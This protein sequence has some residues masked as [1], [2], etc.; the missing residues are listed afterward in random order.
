MVTSQN[1]WRSI[2]N[3]LETALQ[4]E[5]DVNQSLLKLVATAE[6]HNDAQLADY[7]S[8][9]FLGEQVESISTL[10]RYLTKLNR[11]GG[12]GL[13]LYLLDQEVGNDVDKRNSA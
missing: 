9:D 4:L 5:K 13:G 6:E 7:I 10:A 8:S 3:I 12:D 1:E 2:Q 11:V